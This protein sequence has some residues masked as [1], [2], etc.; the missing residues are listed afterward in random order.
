MLKLRGLGQK[1]GQLLAVPHHDDR[2]SP[3]QRKVSPATAVL[4]DEVPE[5]AR[6]VAEVERPVTSAR[7]A[8]MRGRADTDPPL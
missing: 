5:K 4:N 8:V 2:L 3:H 6:K 7:P 1:I